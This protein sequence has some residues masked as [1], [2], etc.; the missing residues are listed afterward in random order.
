MIDIVFPTGGPQGGRKGAHKAEVGSRVAPKVDVE[1]KARV[2]SQIGF[3]RVIAAAADSLV[4]S[5]NHL[6]YKLVVRGT[7]VE[8]GLE[9]P[10]VGVEDTLGIGVRLEATNHR[11][12]RNGDVHPRIVCSACVVAAKLIL[13][14]RRPGKGSNN[15]R[16]AEIEQPQRAERRPADPVSAAA[17]GHGCVGAVRVP[18]MPNLRH[19]HADTGRQ[20]QR[21]VDERIDQHRHV[22]GPVNQVCLV[23]DRGQMAHV[24]GDVRARAG[25]FA[26]NVL[27]TRIPR[28]RAITTM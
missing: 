5:T 23:V 3:L 9:A 4:V 10:A 15:A 17:E 8:E 12:H 14:L 25:K 1:P 11:V 27:E 6:T 19:V 20:R 26:A 21:T 16:V 28:Q 22:V 2:A 18:G 13:P 7:P 24:D